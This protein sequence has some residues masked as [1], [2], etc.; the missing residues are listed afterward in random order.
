MADG[1]SARVDTT[2]ALVGLERLVGPNRLHLARSMAVAGGKAL[3]DE[4]KARAP[5]LTG[6][7]RE[8]IYLAFSPEGSDATRVVYHVSWRKGRGQM[9]GDAPHGHF[10]EFG[11][12][13]THK[14]YI[15]SDGE[16]YSSAEKLDTPRWIAA[17][18]F[19]RPAFESA[20][21]RSLNAMRERGRER[22]PELLSGANEP[23]SELL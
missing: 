8:M 11:H 4:A 7:L 2:K 10:I 12:W 21:A 1:I 5:V 13:Q 14:A 6:R 20:R 18:P 22:L 19:L 17:E 23:G 9:G 3:R 16:W 15:G